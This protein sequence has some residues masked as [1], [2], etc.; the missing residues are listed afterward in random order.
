MPRYT[1]TAIVLHWLIALLIA[2]NVGLALTVGWF[3]DSAVR[4]VIDTHKSTGIT[5]LGLVLVRLIW[6]YRHAPP[7]LPAGYPAWERRAAHAAHIAL[8]ALI[9]ALPLSGWLHDSAWKDAASHPMSLFGTVP[10]PRIGWITSLEP[11]LKEQLH[12]R[13]GALHAWLG[14]ALYAL[15]AAHVAGALKHQWL[16]R[17]RELQRM[18]PGKA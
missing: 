18:W 15:F 10:W 9:L 5:V 7:A 6:R 13:F 4:T 1:T 2:V 17:H 14:Y 8:Y 3:P 12:D 11:G 16:D